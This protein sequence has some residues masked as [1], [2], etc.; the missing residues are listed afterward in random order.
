MGHDQDHKE[1]YDRDRQAN[2]TS[3]D[4]GFGDPADGSTLRVGVVFSFESKTET[5][6]SA[7]SQTNGANDVRVYRRALF[8]IRRN[9]SL[10]GWNLLH[11]SDSTAGSH[12]VKGPCVGP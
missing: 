12:D 2:R 6:D 9:R 8:W 1:D 11:V 3:Q 7:N 10:I 4:G 5:N